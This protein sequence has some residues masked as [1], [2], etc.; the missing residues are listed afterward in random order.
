MDMIIKNE[1]RVELNT[2]IISDVKNDLIQYKCLCCN[3]NYPNN[4]DENL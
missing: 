1:K 2:K 4:F 3:R